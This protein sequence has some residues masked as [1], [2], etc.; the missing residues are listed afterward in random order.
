ML[1]KEPLFL[2][3]EVVG[4]FMLPHLE[5]LIKNSAVIT[6]APPSLV[7]L[8]PFLHHVSDELKDVCLLENNHIWAGC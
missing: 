1:K 5:A 8:W 4:G 6:A 3:A 2:A 7:T